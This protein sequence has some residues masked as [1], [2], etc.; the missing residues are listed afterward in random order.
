MVQSKSEMMNYKL[1]TPVMKIK[2]P[3]SQ[4]KKQSDSDILQNCGEYQGLV[5]Y[6]FK[7]L[8]SYRINYKPSFP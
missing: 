3:M 8:F 6:E 2:T 7:D 1:N 5:K 4:F